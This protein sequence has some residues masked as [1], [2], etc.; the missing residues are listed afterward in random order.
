M[1]IWIGIHLTECTGCQE[2]REH[3]LIKPKTNIS[4]FPIWI[5]RAWEL[6][7]F[8]YLT[9]IKPVETRKIII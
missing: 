6:D 2:Y 7:Q 4:S 1:V 5:C 3:A 9:A 8:V